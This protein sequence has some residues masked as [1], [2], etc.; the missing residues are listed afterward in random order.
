[1]KDGIVGIAPKRILNGGQI[2]FMGIRCD[3]WLSDNA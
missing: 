3:L 1:M 2:R